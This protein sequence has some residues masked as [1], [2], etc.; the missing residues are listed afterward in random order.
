MAENNASESTQPNPEN[1]QV[2]L[3]IDEREMSTSYANGFRTNSTAEE[4]LIDFG[5]NLTAPARKAEEGEPQVAGEMVFHV[6]DR[7]I[8]N[9]Y[10]AKRLAL[11]LGQLVRRHEEQFGELKLNVADRA[12]KS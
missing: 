7:I 2:R 10:T 11:S 9:Y 1:R 12:A 6:N 4:V 8:L 3:R 5:L